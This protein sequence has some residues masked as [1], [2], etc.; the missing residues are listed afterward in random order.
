L[1]DDEYEPI[2]YDEDIIVMVADEQYDLFLPS[3]TKEDEESMDN[4]FENFVKREGPNQIMHLIL[5]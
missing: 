3:K 1:L 4:G 2:T 5:E